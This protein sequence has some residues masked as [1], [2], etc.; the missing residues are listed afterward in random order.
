MDI[1]QLGK[2]I[3]ELRLEQGLTQEELAGA[4]E[5][6]VSY[7]SHIER[8]VKK[9]SLATVIQLAAVLQTSVDSLLEAACASDTE[10][11]AP[12]VYSLLQDCSEFERQ[13][14]F[15]ISRALK[16]VLRD[17]EVKNQENFLPLD[18]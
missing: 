18:L 8:G 17:Y 9:A 3:R 6:S 16:Q 4:A 15:E 7:L 5:L 13:V 2:R 12:D 1:L 10:E 11:L 14:I